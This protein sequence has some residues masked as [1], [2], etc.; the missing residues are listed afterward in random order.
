MQKGDIVILSSDGLIDNL[1]E[2]DILEEV[3]K[4]SH[5]SYDP[6]AA[7]HDPFHPE[8]A[9]YAST[10]SSSS[11]SPSS[12]D[13]DSSAE[14]T[15]SSMAADAVTGVAFNPQR[16]SEALCSRAKA[17]MMDPFVVA[18]PFADRATDEGFYFSGGKKSVVLPFSRATLADRGSAP[19]G[20]TLHASLVSLERWKLQR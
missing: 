4:F 8:A 17:V 5:P 15:A 19:P 10:A 14:E 2:I 6:L 18:S 12:L 9:S 7:D 3:L 1:Y 11:A 20:T 16:L 13:S